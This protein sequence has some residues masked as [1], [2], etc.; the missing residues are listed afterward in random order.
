MNL[1]EWEMEQDL[2]AKILSLGEALSWKTAGPCIL[3]FIEVIFTASPRFGQILK[4]DI[5]TI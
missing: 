3:G 4:I 1:E 5:L 2:H